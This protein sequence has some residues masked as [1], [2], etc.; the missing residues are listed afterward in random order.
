MSM[1]AAWG[2][3]NAFDDALR[4][5]RLAEAAHH[6]AVLG[7]RDAKSL[8]LQLLRDETAGL[9]ADSPEARQL[10]DLALVPGEPPK[11]WIDLITFVVMEPDHRTYRLVQ[12]NQAGREVL[13]E[14]AELGG[15]VER[16]K[17]H[18]AHRLVARDKRIAQT[19]PAAQPRFS[20]NAVATAW[21]AGFGIGLS[22]LAISLIL[23]EKL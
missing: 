22:T 15:M 16:L 12:D 18:M 6:E 20:A 13:H 5:A 1:Q 21:L 11:L 9:I 17:M 7:I 2:R 19:L 14:T 8:R 3:S 4:Q 23:L 10:F